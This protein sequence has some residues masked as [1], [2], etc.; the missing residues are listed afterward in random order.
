MH[1]AVKFELAV[2]EYFIIN[3]RFSQKSGKTHAYIARTCAQLN[4]KNYWPHF[5]I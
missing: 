4:V 5:A 3:N 1:I 2:R